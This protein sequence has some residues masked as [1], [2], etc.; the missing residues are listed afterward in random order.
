[1]IEAPKCSTD[2]TSR[3]LCVIVAF[4]CKFAQKKL[5]SKSINYQNNY[6]PHKSNFG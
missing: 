2:D 6:S 3:L 4:G 5:K 1:M